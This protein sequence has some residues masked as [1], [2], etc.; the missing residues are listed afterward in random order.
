M[1]IIKILSL[2]S[3]YSLCFTNDISLRMNISNNILIFHD[4]QCSCSQDFS[5][6]HSLSNLSLL[7]SKSDKGFREYLLN[8]KCDIIFINLKNL[9]CFL[10]LKL[11]CSFR[12]IVRSLSKYLSLLYYHFI[13][14][15]DQV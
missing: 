4:I 7:W 10:S 13:T 5:L 6:I 3:I 15:F 9:T 11:T 8:S 2:R 12:C 1:L 14:I